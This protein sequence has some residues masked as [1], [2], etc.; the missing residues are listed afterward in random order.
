MDTKPNFR[1]MD[2]RPGRRATALKL[3]IFLA[4]LSVM[5]SGCAR[6]APVTVP[7]SVDKVLEITLYTEKNITKLV[8]VAIERSPS[9]LLLDEI[10]SLGMERASPGTRDYR[11]D[12]VNHLL[13]ELDRLRNSRKAALVVACTNSIARV[14]LALRRRLGTPI[15]IPMPDQAVRAQTFRL[16]IEKVSSVVR[17]VIDYDTLAEATVGFT[18]SDIEE[19]VQETLSIIAEKHRSITFERSFAAWAYSVLEHV[20]KR[21]YRAEH[22]RRN[23]FAAEQTQSAGSIGGHIDPELKIRLLDC[24]QKISRARVRHARILNLHHQ[25]YS[26]KEICTRLRITTNNLYTILSRAR[27]MLHRCLETGEIS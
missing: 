7:V 13:L 12:W 23:L 4:A 15:I 17:A 25:G 3:L 19:I 10:E 11:V 1:K 6:Y 24:L 8:E 26:V 22:K 2:N 27:V 20:I 9:L 16:Y 21:H 14:D 18:P 5:A